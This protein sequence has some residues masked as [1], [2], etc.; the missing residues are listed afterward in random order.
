MSKFFLPEIPP[1]Y[2][3]NWHPFSSNISYS[4][5][6]DRFYII[7]GLSWNLAQFTKNCYHFHKMLL[8]SYFYIFVNNY[9]SF[10]TKNIPFWFLTCENFLLVFVNFYHIF[11]YK[12]YSFEFLNFLKIACY[13]LILANMVNFM[14]I[15]YF[16]VFLT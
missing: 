14:Y 15:F 12:L 4:L 13:I 7:Y 11:L 16:C 2:Q 1:I 10:F 3:N 5:F 9:L 6:V 8:F